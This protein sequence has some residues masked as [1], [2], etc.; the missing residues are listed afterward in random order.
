M[1]TLR[2]RGVYCLPN[3]REL[4]ALKGL[5]GGF[6]LYTTHEWDNYA[7]PTYATN[8]DAR[9]YAGGTQTPWHVT[10]LIDTGRTVAQPEGFS[11]PIS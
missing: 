3:G 4:I 6:L 11:R 1:L 5:Q 8:G 9:L 7:L 10:D 2:E